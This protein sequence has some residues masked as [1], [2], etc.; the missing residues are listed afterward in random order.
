[1]FTKLKKELLKFSSS[2]D[3]IVAVFLVG[4]YARNTYKN[5]SDVDII[6]VTSDQNKYVSDTVWTHFFGIIKKIDVEYYGWVTAFRVFY[7]SLEVEFGIAPLKWIQMP[8]DAGTKQV[9]YDGYKV[10]YEKENILEKIK[11]EIQ[12]SL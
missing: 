9:L 11:L 7:E 8:L 1:M 5:D 3:D 2:N 6:I 12:E 10:I 4:S